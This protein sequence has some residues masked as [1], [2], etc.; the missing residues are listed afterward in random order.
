MTYHV[1]VRPSAAKDIAEARA[2]YE[3]KQAGLGASFLDAVEAALKSI[4]AGP[5]RY[6]ALVRDARRILTR[7][8]P[9]SVYFRVRNDEIRVIAVLHQHRDP[10]L[11]KSRLG[12]GKAG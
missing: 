6:P 11:L 5:Q 3:A 2:W 4:I 1:V 7:R 12:A 9:Y 8:F 10:R